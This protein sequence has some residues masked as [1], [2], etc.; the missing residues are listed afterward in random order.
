MF[1]FFKGERTFFRQNSQVISYTA[2]T[3][4]HTLF[5]FYIY[6]QNGVFVETARYLPNQFESQQY[7]PYFD[8]S[9]VNYSEDTIL[10]EDGRNLYRVMRAFTPNATVVNWTNTTVTNTARIEEYEGNLLRYV[11]KYACEKSILSQLGR[12]ISAIKLG[13]AQVTLV[14]KNKGRFSNNQENLVYVWEDTSTIT[15]TPQLSWY[16][17]TPYSYTYPEY[18]EGT[19]KL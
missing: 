5:E 2:T 18:G 11:D 14:P 13:I 4:V 7:V 10:S 12:D 1:R 3:N 6:L 9:Y 8:P 15:E 16:S 17:G 19:L